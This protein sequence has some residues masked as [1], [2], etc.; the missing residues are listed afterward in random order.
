[1]PEIETIIKMLTSAG[2]T[3][4]G[5][6]DTFLYLEDPSCPVRA[7]QT[8]ME[9]AWIILCVMS[10]LLL[11]AWGVAKIRGIKGDIVNNFKNLFLVC[12]IVSVAVPI[13]NL[14][15]GGDLL[16]AACKKVQVPISEVNSILATRA[17]NGE[18]EYM[19]YEDIDIYD[20]GPKE[21]AA[22]IPD[23]EAA[24]K[25]IQNLE[26]VSDELDA[27]L[28]AQENAQQV[29]QESAQPENNTVNEDVTEISSDAKQVSQE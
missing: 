22:T 2:L 20:S 1:M 29:Q 6:D 5:S 16:A 12:G 19:L 26:S 3:V 23:G 7:F 11:I 10:G 21:S 27:Q 18:M 14:I 25:A 24:L 15:Y 9:Y 13:M 28:T 8:F 4:L 17:Q